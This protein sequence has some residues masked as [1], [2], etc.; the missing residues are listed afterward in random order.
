MMGAKNASMDAPLLMIVVVVDGCLLAVDSLSLLPRLAIVQ[1]M[2]STA[3]DVVA[4]VAV[5]TAIV[6]ILQDYC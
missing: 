3:T 5:D 2:S 1:Q 4:A 6:Q